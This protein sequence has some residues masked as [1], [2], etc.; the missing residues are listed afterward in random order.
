MKKEDIQNDIL[1]LIREFLET[2]EDGGEIEVTESTR[3]LGDDGILDSMGLV[4]IVLD[5]ESDYR[6][7]GHEIS[8]TDE[9]A[10]SQKRSP[11]RSASVLADYILEQ[12]E[13]AND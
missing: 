3:L 9:K 8:L 10:M 12:I 1:T 11:F 7:Q 4:E 5:L 13:Q 2:L 6:D